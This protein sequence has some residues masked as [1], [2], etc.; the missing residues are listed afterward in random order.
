MALLYMVGNEETN[1]WKGGS[2]YEAS[3]VVESGSGSTILLEDEAGKMD[4]WLVALVVTAGSGKIQYTNS[5]RAEVV[6][7]TAVWFDWDA[8]EVSANTN[9]TFFNVAA[10]RAVQV[11]GTVEILVRT[12]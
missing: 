12:S 2:V 6:A 11:S 4:A 7:E 9:D 1:K 5:N 8:G 3:E 10:V